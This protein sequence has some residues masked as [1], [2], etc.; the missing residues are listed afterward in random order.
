MTTFSTHRMPISIHERALRAGNVY[1][2]YAVFIVA[3]IS[4]AVHFI[5]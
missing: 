1:R 5:L 4:A 3:L 2:W